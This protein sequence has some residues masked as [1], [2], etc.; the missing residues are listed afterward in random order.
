MKKCVSLA[1]LALVVLAAD[2]VV[3]AQVNVGPNIN[4][5]TGSDVFLQR[6][7]ELAY[8]VSSLN[9]EHHIALWNDWRT[10]DQADDTGAGTSSQGIFV[11]LFRFFR[12]PFSKAEADADIE[13]AAEG[14]TG[15][16]VSNNGGWNWSTGLVPGF[17][18][19]T[20]PEG[21]ALR[22]GDYEAM[23]DPWVSCDPVNCHVTTIA[24]TRGGGSALVYFR[25]TDFNDSE[26]GHNW[27][28][29]VPPTIL[30]TGNNSLPGAF[31]DKPTIIAA[32]NGLVLIASVEFD[33][34]DKGGKFQSKVM[35]TRSTNYGMTWG[36]SQKI[37]MPSTRNQSP[38][39]VIDPNNSNR[40]FV[41]WRV[42]SENAIV[43]RASFDGGVSWVPNKPYTVLPNFQAYDQIGQQM[44]LAPPARQQFR[45]NAYV[46]G[47]MDGSGV[48]HVAV[49]ER[50]NAQG[51]PTAGG[52]PRIVVT[53]SY[54]GGIS[55]TP[56][57]PVSLTGS[58]PQFIPTMTIV[59]APRRSGD[60]NNKTRADIFLAYYGAD[61]RDI[62][63]NSSGPIAGGNV[64]FH[65]YLSHADSWKT[66]TDPQATGVNTAGNVQFDPATLLSRYTK[67]SLPP[68]GVVTAA[69][70]GVTSENRGYAIFYGG[71]GGFTGDYNIVTQRVPFVRRNGVWRATTALD[72]NA[73][74]PAPAAQIAWADTRD[75][76]LP[77]NPPPT[78]PQDL[79]TYAWWN[80]SPPGTGS[81]SLCNPGSRNQNPYTAEATM[82]VLSAA[83]LT[84][85]TPNLPRSYPLYVQNKTASQQVWR[86]T[87]DAA[88]AASFTFLPPAR[89]VADFAIKPFST[90]T[91]TVFVDQSFTTPFNVRLQRFGSI[92]EQTGEAENPL[93]GPG[94]FTVVTLNTGGGTDPI[95]ATQEFHDPLLDN[96]VLVFTHAP[97]S[98]EPYVQDDPNQNPLGQNPLGQN[99]LGQNPFGQNPF[100]QNATIT[101]YT[102]R[103]TNGG[104]TH[105]AYK[106]IAQIQQNLDPTLY[107]FQ[108]IVNR[109][110]RAPGLS[111]KD[112]NT[113][114]DQFQ[115]IQ[116]SN[117]EN[118]LGQ[119]PLG[120]NPFGQNPFGQN[121]LG[122]NPFGQN[123]LGQNAIVSDNSTFY[124]APTPGSSTARREEA[125]RARLA[126]ARASGS[127][128]FKFV[129]VK[130]KEEY[131]RIQAS[132]AD[133]G[134]ADRTADQVWYTIR[135]GQLRPLVA[136]DTVFDPTQLS[137]AVLSQAPNVELVDGQVVV[138][139]PPAAFKAA[140]LRYTSALT[141]LPPRVFPGGT[142][143]LPSM[144]AENVGSAFAG[145]FRQGLYLRSKTTQSTTFLGQGPLTTA[146]V[147]PGGTTTVGG[148]TALL[149][150][151]TVPVGLYDACAVVDNTLLVPESNEINN[152][153]CVDIE[154]FPHILIYGP[155]FAPT[156][157]QNERTLAES[158]GHQVRIVSGTSWRNLTTSDFQ[159]YQ[160]IVIPEPLNSAGTNCVDSPTERDALLSDA[161]F[162]K[163]QWSKAVTGPKV[164]IGTDALFHA[165]DHPEGATLV[166]NALRYVVSGPGTGFYMGL[167]CYYHP[168]TTAT[169]VT[170]LS[171]LGLFEMRNAS[172]PLQDET[173]EILQRTHPVML[174]LTD[175]GLSNWNDSV[176][177][178]FTTFPTGWQVLATARGGEPASRPYIISFD[179]PPII[180]F[181]LPPSPDGRIDSPAAAHG[182]TAGRSVRGG[183][184]P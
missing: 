102:F 173:V 130:S 144:T 15:F 172:P 78:I 179:P 117:M 26:T 158:N 40:V 105:S 176:H 80:Y 98:I 71:R 135:V 180:T 56:R 9:P 103:V 82:G 153:R 24:F 150:P 101:D 25:Y 111:R 96:E 55:W 79:D 155:T 165:D 166:G 159:M 62:A 60:P 162:N 22:A 112:C 73:V 161:N 67:D 88:A 18:G 34:Q 66:E 81:L 76:I 124:I 94:T 171:E 181:A 27:R 126:N 65:M 19:D 116:I 44:P 97:G 17:P 177:E 147:A 37:S 74:L 129:R 183:T 4:I 109:V 127:S 119:N 57:K 36:P 145:S 132:T 140:D 46:T 115:P 21:A 151:T 143:D 85:K 152:T 141:G 157:A 11:R 91:G 182:L 160:A 184:R 87:I 168:N 83:P 68:H 23:A 163:P 31:N 89:K 154:V 178:V 49:S 149:V 50:V 47:G 134:L 8:G 14:W 106:A 7:N 169:P 2:A 39:F 77:G 122:Q 63:A 69:G 86:A 29:T 30:K 10:I 100:G 58:G 113:L 95:A 138:T 107:K 92:N 164:L 42:F 59:G 52:T 3:R 16:G 128:G 148:A 20:S 121:P 104:T 33:G 137:V 48:L 13:A 110:S 72:L 175:A 99:P 139:D 28:L 53:S 45:T 123:P 174:N 5:A 146:A 114:G 64:R 131:L 142:L 43:G 136:G 61:T 41:G 170:V 90:V 118:P 120:Q 38:F 167:S 93:S 108:V 1:A 54:N 133:F 32:P 84:F 70:F 6:Q 35:V 75:I 125:S 51:V 12:K 156:L